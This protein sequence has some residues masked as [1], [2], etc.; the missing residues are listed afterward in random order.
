MGEVENLTSD[1][2][3]K[4]AEP[5]R[6]RSMSWTSTILDP[7][8]PSLLTQ[9]KGFGSDPCSPRGFILVLRTKTI[10][11][12]HELLKIVIG[13]MPFPECRLF[14]PDT[15]RTQNIHILREEI[16]DIEC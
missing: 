12:K 11:C 15:L 1:P 9:R 8:D 14:L 6:E 5:F 3:H 4:V 10:R 16:V 2:M 13:S 7:F